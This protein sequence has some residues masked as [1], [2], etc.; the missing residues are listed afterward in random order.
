MIY[1]GT[2]PVTRKTDRRRRANWPTYVMVSVLVV[3][4]G[5]CGAYRWFIYDLEE[6]PPELTAEYESSEALLVAEDIA[7]L[8]IAELPV[9][10]DGFS[11]F[12]SR[13]WKTD[14]CSS[15]WDGRVSWDGFVS[16][17]VRY[18]L[19]VHDDDFAQRI[20]YA[21]AIADTLEDLG[22][23]PTQEPEGDKDVSVRAKRDDGLSI[24][25][26][27]SWGL[28]ITTDCVVQDDETVYTPPHV[29]ISPMNDH[30]DL[31]RPYPYD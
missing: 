17:S 29:R 13:G 28:S 4:A 21:E 9:D 22:L 3:F 19:D 27:S 12:D 23:E 14:T 8:I 26:S 7:G 11:A 30:Q 15:G 20:E 1:L 16:V 10:G 31:E 24:R 2:P 5:C 6:R 25:Y 18:G